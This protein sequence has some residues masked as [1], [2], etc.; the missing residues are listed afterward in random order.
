MNKI[1]QM[2][3]IMK[4]KTR[5]IEQQTCINAHIVVGEPRLYYA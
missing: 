5:N 2:N 4:T 1:M 3:K